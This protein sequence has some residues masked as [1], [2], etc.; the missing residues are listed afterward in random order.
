MYKKEVWG[1]A[2]LFFALYRTILT[3]IMFYIK[4]VNLCQNLHC[5]SWRNSNLYILILMIIRPIQRSFPPYY[6]PL[7]LVL[8]NTSLTNLLHNISAKSRKMIVQ[9]LWK[10]LEGVVKDTRDEPFLQ[11][12]NQEAS[13]SLMHHIECRVDLAH[14]YSC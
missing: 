12:F 7:F 6:S 9:L 3:I 2:T 4:Y 10:L 13:T 5:L 11:T 8:R 1:I 14:F